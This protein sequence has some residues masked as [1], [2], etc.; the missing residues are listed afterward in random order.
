MTLVLIVRT[1]EGIAVVSD[2][3]TTANTEVEMY[4]EMTSVEYHIYNRR[5]ISKIENF[6]VI[7]AGLSFLNGKT[8]NQIVDRIPDDN[9]DSNE[10]FDYCVEKIR[11]KFMKEIKTEPLV[12]NWEKGR[13]ILSIGI[14]GFEKNIPFVHRLIFFRNEKE[15]ELI[16]LVESDDTFDPPHFGIDYFGDFEFVQ[17]VIRAA[18]KENLLKPFDILTI[19]DALELARNLMQFL[20]EFQKFMVT[21]TVAYPIESVVITLEDGFE[22]VDRMEFKKFH[23]DHDEGINS[24]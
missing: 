19:H 10:G 22:W 6:A 15:G 11:T 16:E 21:F 13:L 23:Y 5:K 9:P 4:G 2:T 12:K 14:I 20:I 1:R 3:V 24:M 18:K 8:I 17:L 7:H